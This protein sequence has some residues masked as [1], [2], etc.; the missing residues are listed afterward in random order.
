MINMASQ[1]TSGE[2]VGWQQLPAVEFNEHVG[3]FYHR[4]VVDGSVECA[5]RMESK[6]LN[7]E[8]IAHGGSLLTFADYCLYVAAAHHAKGSVV[9]V[10]LTSE[11]LG[12]V[13]RG[14]LVKAKGSVISAGRSLIFARGLSFVDGRNVLSF[15][16]VFKK[17]RS[18]T[19]ISPHPRPLMES[20]PQ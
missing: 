4:F 16:G 9:T 7:G 20:E 1:V 14:E 19:S 13:Q 3:P 15:S 5:F 2:F 11:F 17:L 12:S 6:N 18:P 10:S 8:D